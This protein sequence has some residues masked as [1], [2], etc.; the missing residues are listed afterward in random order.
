M[1]FQEVLCDTTKVCKVYSEESQGILEVICVDNFGMTTH[2]NEQQGMPCT[3]CILCWYLQYDKLQCRVKMYMTQ[4]TK[5]YNNFQCQYCIALRTYYYIHYS[6]INYT[7][8]AGFTLHCIRED[9]Q[10]GAT[11]Y[12]QYINQCT[13]V[14]LTRIMKSTYYVDIVVQYPTIQRVRYYIEQDVHIITYGQVI[15]T[16]WVRSHFQICTPY[17]LLENVINK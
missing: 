12:Q 13:T 5:Q 6:G 3:F 11:K 1:Y 15:V 14:D 10:L 2:Y 16:P 17:S 8:W 4:Y 9:T 7:S